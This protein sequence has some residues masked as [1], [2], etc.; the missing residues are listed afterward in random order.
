MTP[1]YVQLFR[2]EVRF[3]LVEKRPPRLEK[4]IASIGLPPFQSIECKPLPGCDPKRCFVNVERQV[5]RAGGTMEVGFIFGEYEGRAY[6]GEAHAIW[7]PRFGRPLDITPHRFQ[8]NRVLF[9]ASEGVAAKRGKTASPKLIISDDPLVK[10]VEEFDSKL[11]QIWEEAFQGFGVE[12]VIPIPLVKQAAAEVG[13]PAPV[14]RYMTE[15]RLATERQYGQVYSPGS[16][17]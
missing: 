15:A 16:D 7:R 17:H 13:L 12:M 2:T 8:P 3:R 1:E 10:A 11:A 4:F 14:A 5:E 9:T 6:Q